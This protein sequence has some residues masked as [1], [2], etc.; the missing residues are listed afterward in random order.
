MRI[1]FVNQYYQPDLAATAQV[2]GDLAAALA[3]RG[4]EVH[5]LCSRGRY[6]RATRSLG[7]PPR[8]E[9]VAG[10]NIHRL[11][12]TGFGK[13]GRVGRAVD[14][15]SFHLLTGLRL[16]LAGWRYDVIV[17]LTTPPLI[18]IYA[19]PV[20]WFSRTRHVCW[21]MDLHPDCEFELGLLRP[22]SLTGRLLDWLDRRQLRGADACVV[23]GTCMADRLKLKGVADSRLHVVPVWTQIDEPPDNK[24]VATQ[25]QQLNAA[26]RFVVMYSGNAGLIH[27]F[28]AL[29]EVARRLRDEPGIVFRIVGGGR[30]MPEIKAF[31]A[32]NALT[33]VTLHPYVEGTDLAAS[34]AAGDLHVVTLRDA[35]VGVAVPS[36][37]YSVLAVG[38]PV[39]FIG[40][41]ESHA[42]RTIEQ[43]QAGTVVAT[44]D[45]DGLVAVIRDAAAGRGPATATPETLSSA[46]RAEKTASLEAWHRLLA[47]VV[48]PTAMDRMN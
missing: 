25:R 1:L 16:L 34:L 45:V 40:P 29:L 46:A 10:V 22:T 44:D 21:V 7:R 17:T 13:S 42:A 8:R 2:L 47:S 27:T 43:W 14:Y 31:V 11:T 20:K 32:A 36:K 48:H 3:G 12:A 4:H 15:A 24:V 35:L 26:D 39:V 5:V 9:R 37:L 41:R 19:T 28:D 23:L 38:R 18:G 33:N 6:D 30:R